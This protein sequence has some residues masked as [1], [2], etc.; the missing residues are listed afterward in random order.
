MTPS[1]RPLALLGAAAA[2]ISAFGQRAT[3]LFSETFNGPDLPAGWTMDPAAVE[4]L[5][6]QGDSLHLTTAPWTI[7]NAATANVMGYF[8]VPDDPVANAF[9][10][11]N[12]DAPPCNCILNGVALESPT[13][14]LT[15][16]QHAALAFRAYH[17]GLP[18]G[19]KAWVE[20][21]S[22][23]ADWDTLFFLPAM[24]GAWQDHTLDLSA[25]D[26][27]PLH[28]R[29][30]YD[31]QGAWASGMAVDDVCVFGRSAKDLMAVEGLLGDATASAFNTS[32]R[33]LGY[34][35]IPQVQQ[36]ALLL[37][38]RIRNVG[39]D[40][41]HALSAHVRIRLDGAVQQETD[42]ALLDTLAPLADTTLSW[43]SGWTSPATG[44]VDVD[45]TLSSADPDAAPDDNV[46]ATA[47]DVT[48]PTDAAYA[49][50]ID[51]D[52]PETTIGTDTAG[53]STGCRFELI[54][55]S[56][57]VV[58]LSVRLAAGTEEGASISALLTNGT[59][60]AV[61]S[62]SATHLV[63]AEDIAMSLAGGAVY[64]PFDSAVVVD[65]DQDVL[66]LVHYNGSSGLLHVAAGG[67]VPVGSAWQ[68]ASDGLSITYPE[69]API[70]RL[71]FAG[72][73]TGIAPAAGSHDTAILFP[74]P[75]SDGITIRFPGQARGGRTVDVLGPE[76]QQV[77]RLSMDS[78][79]NGELHVDVSAWPSGVYFL[80]MVDADRS[81]VGRFLVVH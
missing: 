58:G 78:S 63:T 22:D 43:S 50:A 76:G 23:G 21:S 53:F 60:S 71:H 40:T 73:V 46:Q 28:L 51:N 57:A 31:D 62:G 5:D 80:R 64:L 10:M 72:A 13:I 41:A 14:D 4:R 20:A 66:A 38:L 25:Y 79:A 56:D 69:R 17:D 81:Y 77:A 70:V 18:G 29:F 54:P 74:D 7:G 48:G 55:C 16:V 19:T 11:V 8:P 33:S 39:S 37:S 1:L 9:A 52:L 30:R 65:E 26:G 45:W 47:Y 42:V 59:I 35:L 27:G 49:M 34:R 3:C 15:G 61:L 75:A 36:S 32:T 44:H 2:A 24:Q 68:I 12:D 6:Q 67:K